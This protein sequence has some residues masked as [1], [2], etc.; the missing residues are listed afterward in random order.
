MNSN[1][2]NMI[3][4]R[5]IRMQLVNVRKQKNLTQKQ[6]S[7]ISGLSESC[8]SSIESDLDHSPTLRSLLR[9]ANALDIKIYISEN[10]D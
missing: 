5:L 4:D 6:L 2:D 1:T 10:V 3:A 8:I 7:T 9:Y